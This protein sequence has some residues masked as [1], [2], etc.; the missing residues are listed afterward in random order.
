MLSKKSKPLDE[1]LSKNTTQDVIPISANL[2]IENVIGESSSETLQGLDSATINDSYYEYINPNDLDGKYVMV[3]NKTTN[4]IIYEKNPDEICYP[5]STTK[6]LTACV[7][8]EYISADTIFTVGDELSLVP[9]DSSLAY[10]E[11]GEKIS[12]K[13][14]VYAM[15]LPS[16]NDASYTVAVNVARRVSG[17]SKM[18]AEDG[19]EYFAELM[20]KTAQNIGMSNSNFVVP[21]GFHD[22]EHYVTARDMMKLL[23]YLDNFPLI[24]EAGSTYRYEV[25]VSSGQDYIWLN[26]NRLIDK[27]SVYYYEG[28]GLGKTGFHDDAGHC[29][30]FN[31]NKNGIELY[32]VVMDSQT[33]AYRNRDC[34]NLLNMVYNPTEVKIGTEWD[35]TTTSG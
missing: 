27:S 21:D 16:G 3:Y 26:S 4:E 12:L 32:V 9:P 22:D 17:D 24:Q 7:A 19:I 10:I 15:L 5:A 18:S 2:N 13:D 20:N 33:A 35:T 30:A 11:E 34:I 28:V 14:L 31:C 29:I 23:L 1:D 8:L 6:L 25:T